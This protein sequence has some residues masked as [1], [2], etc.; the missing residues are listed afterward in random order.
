MVDEMN[1]EERGDMIWKE[2]NDLSPLLSESFPS[3]VSVDFSQNWV[4]EYPRSRTV[5]KEAFI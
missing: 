5:R 4:R 1:T 3:H 2:K